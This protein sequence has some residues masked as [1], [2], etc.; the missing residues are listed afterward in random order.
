MCTKSNIKYILSA[1][2]TCFFLTLLSGHSAAAIDSQNHLH[3]DAKKV[4]D[5]WLTSQLDYQQL[6][7]LSISYAKGQSLVFNESYGHIEQS[8]ITPVDNQTIASICSI[9]KVFTATAIM[10]LVDQGKLNL[11]DKLSDLLPDLKMKENGLSLNNVKLIHLLNHTSGLPRD[12][13]HAY[14]SGPEHN[15]PSK[16]GLY[17]SLAN[18]QL[19]NPTDK[20]SNYSN[21]GYAL[22]GQIIERASNTSYKDYIEKEIFGPLGMSDSVVEMSASNYG[23]NHAL[24]YT[25]INRNGKRKQ[26]NFYTTKAMQAATGISSNAKDLA[27]FA[28][29]QFRTLKATQPEL[30]HPDTLQKMYQTDHSPATK[31]RGLG[32]QIQTSQSGD[33]W[34][35]HGGMCPGYNSFIQLNTTDQEAFTVIASAN[36]VR[37]LAYINNLKDILKSAASLQST[38]SAKPDFSDYEG[39]Y[40]LNPWNSEYYVGAWGEGLVLLYLP[41]ESVKYAMHHYKKVGKDTFQLIKE[42]ELADEF[43]V[44]NRDE[45]GKVI[46]VTNDGNHHNKL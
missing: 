24:G 4:I 26:A 39:F 38:S 46:S 22:L 15:F 21:V 29:W 13:H 40:D 9:S 28:M 37:A 12:T 23:K 18:Q 41:V 43:I 34:A 35:M 27:K 5:V 42:G 3:P 6:P 44:F 25:A 14:W 30:M 31:N 19:E 8:R 16:A 36:K 32:Y 2:I 1:A 45:H 11:Q 17:E 7:F 20:T 10:K 33:V